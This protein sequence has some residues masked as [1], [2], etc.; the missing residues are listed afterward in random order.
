MKTLET[1]MSNSTQKLGYWSA[2]VI[3][4][5]F[6]IYI[7]CFVGI[8]TTSPLFIWTKIDDYIAY[9][10]NN[11]MFFAEL[12]KFFMLL[13]GIAYVVLISAFHEFAEKDKKIFSRISLSFGIAFMITI[14]IHYFVQISAVRFALSDGNTMGLEHFIQAN[15]HSITSS[16]NMLGWTVFFGLSSLFLVPIF[17]KSN[18][19][20]RIS[21]LMNGING[22]LGA[23]AFV[24]NIIPILAFTAYIGLGAF[25]FLFSIGSI[26]FFRK[27]K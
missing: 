24:F 22:L 7:I 27:M 21:F 17:D 15:P 3:L 13:M 4:T 6:I 2:I 14:C 19:L 9:T 5:T 20:L 16:I 10:Q 11:N 18:K 1:N 26:R 23:F 25:V 12:A 8:L